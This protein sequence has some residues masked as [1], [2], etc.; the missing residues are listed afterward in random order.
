MSV[1]KPR[2][3]GK[4]LV[5]L[6]TK[7]DRENHETLYAYAQFLGEPTDYILN[8]LIDTVLAKDKEFQAWRVEHTGS[9]V[10]Q[11][12]RP[13]HRVRRREAARHSTAHHMSTGNATAAGVNPRITS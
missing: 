13:P 7:L 1:I 11:Q 10:P 8:Q 2:T 12:V 9:Y 6:M 4:E 5:R 3:R